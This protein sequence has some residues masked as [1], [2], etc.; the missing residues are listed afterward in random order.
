[1]SVAQIDT[2]QK[3]SIRH[4]IDYI[5]KTIVFQEEDIEKLRRSCDRGAFR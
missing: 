2:R 5:E 1:M 3:E 4:V